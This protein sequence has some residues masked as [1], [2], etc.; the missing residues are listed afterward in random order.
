MKS[1]GITGGRVQQAPGGFTP[2]GHPP[3]FDDLAAIEG[4]ECGDLWAML[5]VHAARVHGVREHGNDGR[6]VVAQDALHR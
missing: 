5:Y 2:S 3:A 1:P 6:A 4:A